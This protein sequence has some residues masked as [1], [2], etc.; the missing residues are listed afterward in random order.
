MRRRGTGI[1]AMLM[2]AGMLIC[3]LGLSIPL[4]MVRDVVVLVGGFLV[5]FGGMDWYHKWK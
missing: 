3:A 2:L 1:S 5:L 4:P